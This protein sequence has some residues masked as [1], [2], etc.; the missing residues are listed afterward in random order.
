M[1][2][3]EHSNIN[4]VVQDHFNLVCPK[5][6]T[7]KSTANKRTQ[8]YRSNSVYEKIYKK[9]NSYSGTP[10][11]SLFEYF[12]QHFE[13]ILTGDIDELTIVLF[14][15]RRIIKC[16][17]LK[18]KK[19]NDEGN[20][21][22]TDLGND[23]EFCFD[24]S[25]YSKNEYPYTILTKLGINSC[26]YCNRQ[27]VNTYYSNSGKV[28]A[29][30]DHFYS[31]TI[32]PYFR[33]SFYNLIPSCY[34]CNSSLKGKKKFSNGSHLNPYSCSFESIIAFTINYKKSNNDSAKYIAEFYSN[35]NYL[36]IEF[37]E[38][39]KKNNPVLVKAK[40]NI[41]DFKIIEL[42][43]LHKDF[44]V[45]LLQK[46]VIYNKAGYANTLAQNYPKLFDGENDVLRMVLGNYNNVVDFNKR[47][48]SRLIRDI[49]A[50]LNF[51]Q[52]LTI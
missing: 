16:K 44:I 7:A 49:S 4:G 19:I 30:L 39:V 17:R 20:I 8:L 48:F 1:N 22:N 25:S 28:R 27:F 36:Q 5:L 13:K 33:I 41:R 45:E 51:T 32:H 24:Y 31:Q 37:K 23:I 14:R 10:E 29:T 46:E 21:V 18:L 2:L 50:E 43:N 42:Y 34:S 12:E 26:P 47:P 11:F 40:N 3:I 38:L 9:R 15:I 52:R 6:K 35:S